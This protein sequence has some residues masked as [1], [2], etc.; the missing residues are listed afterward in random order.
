VLA[1]ARVVFA[2]RSI[3][4]GAAAAAATPGLTE[5]RELDLASLH[6]VRAAT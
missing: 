4:K 1:G 3:E 2:V 5:V 6:S